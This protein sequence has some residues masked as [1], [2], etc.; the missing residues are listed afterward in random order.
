MSDE[1]SKKVLKELEDMENGFFLIENKSGNAILKVTPAGK[2]GT[3]VEAIQV[4]TRVQIFGVEEYDEREIRKIVKNADGKEHIIGKW[5]GGEPENSRAEILIE[6]NNMEA[7][8]TLFPPKHG[9]YMLDDNGI[10]ISGQTLFTLEFQ[11]CCST[12]GLGNKVNILK[13]FNVRTVRRIVRYSLSIESSI[14]MKSN[15]H[16]LYFLGKNHSELGV[17]A[18]QYDAFGR[19]FLM[20]LHHL[21]KEDLTDVAVVQWKTLLTKLIRYMLQWSIEQLQQ[22]LEQLQHQCTSNGNI[23]VK[24]Q[25]QRHT[26]LI[27]DLNELE[28]LEDIMAKVR[29]RSLSEPKSNEERMVLGKFYGVDTK[30]RIRLQRMDFFQD[31]DLYT[32][33]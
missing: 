12:L 26:P 5:T 25:G 6:S 32:L 29:D 11:K 8:I 10:R 19:A 15:E 1:Y 28:T 23:T 24:A 27:T 21:L 4:I 7:S 14:H 2:L 30:S 18:S 22:S 9:G 20:T 13:V 33:L 17:N 31:G 3:K 16:K